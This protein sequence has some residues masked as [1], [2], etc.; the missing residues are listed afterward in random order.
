MLAFFRRLLSPRRRAR[1]LILTLVVIPALLLSGCRAA[2]QP[3]PAL[4]TAKQMTLTLAKDPD[5]QKATADGRRSLLTQ[6]GP[7]ESFLQQDLDEQRALGTDP[8][9]LPDVLKLQADMMDKLAADP[10]LSER[11][12]ANNMK[13]FRDLTRDPKY[14]PQLIAVM[15]DLMSDPQMQ[16]ALK[17]MIAQMAGGAAGGAGG[18]GAAAGGGAGGRT[19]GTTPATPAPAR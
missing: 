5:V 11:V 7:R 15:L 12:K 17:A 6:T 10:T 18:G 14:R 2:R 1:K 16:A 19:G 9:Y 8:R 13:V 4:N 3:E